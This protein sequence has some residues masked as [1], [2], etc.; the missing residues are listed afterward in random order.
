VWTDSWLSITG[1]G[2]D[3]TG[4]GAGDEQARKVVAGEAS[5]CGE[6]MQAWFEG[7]GGQRSQVRA[8]WWQERQDK[9][10]DGFLAESQNQGRAGT[11]WE[12]SQEW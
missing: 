7:L 5:M 4:V 2:C 12:P 1:V 10:V 3:F 11:S 8:A 6:D 9:V